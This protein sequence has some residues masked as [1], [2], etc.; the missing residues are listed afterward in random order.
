MSRYVL[1]FLGAFLVGIF[2]GDWFYL[3]FGY[4]AG[5]IGG[6]VGGLI[7]FFHD[8]YYRLVLILFLGLMLGFTYYQFWDLKENQKNLV[9]GQQLAAY[10]VVAEKPEIDK[11]QK[12]II[13]H[14]NTKILVQ[15]AKYPRYNYG[16]ILEIKGEIQNPKLIKS[17]DGSNFNYG[18][19]LLK[20]GIRGIIR[21]PKSIKV[22][23][24]ANNIKT[25]I[26]K[27][28][29][30]AG[31]KFEESLARILAEPY[32]A[33]QV[34][35]LLGH[36]SRLPDSLVSAFNRTGTTHIV[37][38][39]GY[40]ITIIISAL[41]IFLM[42]Y[43]RRLAFWGSLAAVLVFVILTGASA[44]VVRAAVL[45][46]ADFMDRVFDGAGE[47]LY[48]KKR[49]IVSI[50]VFGIRWFSFSCAACG[51]G[52]NYRLAAENNQNQFGGNFGRAN[53]GVA[54][55][56]LQFRRFIGGGAAGKCFNFADDPDCHGFGVCR[57]HCGNDL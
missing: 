43:S 18:E 30:F 23:G 26:Y 3:E 35:L 40:N 34:G 45:S 42:R 49:C 17:A 13:A 20:K 8:Q 15:T 5:I 47:S 48:F 19:Y 21:N 9:Y 7:M 39:S 55:F 56:N 57:R 50:V 1:A 33:F 31:D 24:S 41:A 51:R 27:I 29:F 37:A 54:D 14:Q 11:D 28:I 44:S 6:L 2:C 10:G 32:A 46:G 16:D 53:F 36:R 25:K 38:V 4:L 12:L 52:Q 22:V